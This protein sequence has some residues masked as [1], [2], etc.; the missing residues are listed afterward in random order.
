MQISPP[1]PFS[2]FVPRAQPETLQPLIFK[3]P[4]PQ[5]FQSRGPVQKNPQPRIFTPTPS[6]TSRQSQRLSNKR[7]QP[8]IN[9]ST[10]GFIG[11]IEELSNSNQNFRTVIYTSNNLQLVL[12]SLQPG[13]EIGI[14]THRDSD[15]FLRIE[16]GTGIIDV[17]G[18]QQPYQDGTAILV[19]KGISHN[20]I[21]RT[22]TKLYSLYSPPHHFH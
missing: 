19:P 22:A 1:D 11:N 2:F 12:M 18:V 20:L 5:N 9:R 4:A 3:V 13:Q 17:A 8:Q 10:S 15:Q 7:N 6:N 16:S 21:A 14:E